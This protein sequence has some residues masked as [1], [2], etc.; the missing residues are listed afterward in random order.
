VARQ[1]L[2][3]VAAGRDPMAEGR[4]RKA[5]ARRKENSLL[6]VALA[7]YER[8]LARRAIVNRAH[9]MSALRRDLLGA[10]GDVDVRDLGRPTLVGLFRRIAD[11]GRPGAAKDLRTRV[12]VFLNWC[13]NE[14]LMLASPSLG[15]ATR[16]AAGARSSTG[17]GGRSRIGNCRSSGAAST[18]PTTRSS[19]PT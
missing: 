6:S 1:R 4:A 13:A 5:E 19:P 16:A 3:E 7:S 14:G 10:L 9:W 15:T 12:S 18:R 8:D 2:G 11:G 17:Q